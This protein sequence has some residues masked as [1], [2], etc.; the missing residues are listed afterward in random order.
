MNRSYYVKEISTTGAA[1][2][3]ATPY[4]SREAALRVIIK[5]M[6]RRNIAK[7]WIEDQDGHMV[8]PPEDVSA[9]FEDGEN[10]N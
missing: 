9:A 1:L 5:H 6:M 8:M 3:D 2:T 4:G 10:S 7:A